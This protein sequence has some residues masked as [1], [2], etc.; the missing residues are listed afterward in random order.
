M[1]KDLIIVGS[2]PIA[3]AA[4]LFFKDLKIALISSRP[5]ENLTKPV[6]L[7]A[8][9]KESC[10]LLK[11]AGLSDQILEEAQAINQ[12]RVVDHDSHSKVDFFPSS[13][14]LDNFG[15]FLDETILTNKLFEKVEELGVEI[16]QPQDYEIKSKDY[17]SEVAIGGRTLK[18]SLILVAEGKES[19]V[20]Q[21]LG[22]AV[23]S[24]DYKE[25]ALVLDISHKNWPHRGIAVEKFTPSGPFA[26][27][28][29]S[30]NGGTESSLVWV[31]KGLIK[32][33][34][35]LLLN[36]EEIHQLVAKKLDGYLE[37]FEIISEIKSF[38]LKLIQAKDRYKDRIVLVGDAAQ[39][40]HPLAGQGFNLGLRDLKNLSDLVLE[41][42]RLG[43]DLASA[44]PDYSISR[45]F[46]VELIIGFTS[47][48]TKIFSNDI[49]PLKLLRR[50]GLR[51]FDSCELA[52]KIFI[53]YACG[54]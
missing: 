50:G 47:S 34:D 11:K 37:P 40:I 13:L 53:K 19:I 45:N 22:I 46:D 17:C 14:N 16:I 31:E 51:L 18:T 42:K 7:F 52:K 5:S 23:K 3:F 36:Q 27:L 4:A 1:E 41:R 6:R 12:I 49:W 44:L 10:N 24:H 15:F 9:A 35:L 8:L 25:T 39:A 2:G 26:I 29:K 21:K 38:P 20:R 30:Q 54:L 32:R 28:P 33:Q 43:L 48:L